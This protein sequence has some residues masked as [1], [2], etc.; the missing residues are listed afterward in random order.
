MEP[1]TFRHRLAAFAS[2]VNAVTP[3]PVFGFARSIG[4]HRTSFV[5]WYPVGIGGQV[6]E[7]AGVDVIETLLRFFGA[8][9]IVNWPLPECSQPTSV[10][11]GLGE[12]EPLSDE[13]ASAIELLARGAAPVL[14][15]E[16]PIES[17]LDRLRRLDESAEVVTALTDAL[18]V[19]DVFHRIAAI[20]RN[21]LPH[22]AIS[23]GLF[24][25][26]LSR[27]QHYASSGVDDVREGP[28]PYPLD[29]TAAWDYIIIDDAPILPIEKDQPGVTLGFHSSLRVAVRLGDRVIGGIDFMSREPATYSWTDVVVGRRIADQVALALS[30]QRL[31]EESRRLAALAERT[32]NLEML[33]GLLGTVTGVLDVRDVFT[34]ISEIASKVLPHDAM[35]LP[36]LTDDRQHVIPFATAGLPTGL[37]PRILPLPPS[38]RSLVTEP[39]DCQIIDNMQVDSASK[40]NPFALA[41]YRACLRVPVRLNGEIAG[42][43]AFFSK[44]PGMYKHED[45]LI[46]RRI[47]DHVAMVMSHERLADES[48]RA[49]ALQERAANLQMLDGLL[50]ALTGVLDVREVFDRISTIGNTVMPHDG[51]TITVARPVGNRITVYAATGALGHLPVPFDIDIP[52]ASLLEHVWDFELV[53]DLQG[54]P[55]YLKAPSAQAGMRGLLS[56]PFWLGGELKGSVNFFSWVPK[57]FT[58]DD[59]PIARRI[60]DHIGL[61]LSHHRLAEQARLNEELRVRAASVD[62]L[63]EALATLSDSGELNDVF[64]RV[65]AITAKVLPHDGLAL[66]VF[67]PDGRHARR[68]VSSGMDPSRLPQQVEVPDAVRDPNWD[69]DIIDELTL[70][71]VPAAAPVI[72][73]GM[74]SVLR[75]SVRLEGRPVAGLAF[76]SR[77]R[78]AFKK[79]DVAVARRVADR[80]ALSLARERGLEAAKRADEAT[81]RARK[82]ESRV[83]QLT[84]E[85]DVR[86]G[87]RRVVGNSASWRQVLTQAT[88]VAATETTVLLLGESGTGKEVVARLVHRASQRRDGPFIAL[89]CAALPEQLL[90]A[91]LFGYERGAFTGATQSKPGQ[92]EQASGGVLFLDE[93]GEMSLPAQAKFL[94]VLQE[95]E[96][97]RLGGTRVL[98]TDARIVA[99]TNRDL[100]KAMEQGHFREDLFYRLNVFAI[101]LPPLR[102]RKEDI[103]PLSDAFLTEFGRG[104]GRPPAG[105]SREAKQ[106]LLDYEW[107]G[108]VRELRNI[109]ERAAILCDGGLITGDHLALSAATVVR[110]PAP[111]TH[112]PAG[113]ASVPPPP[114]PREDL[115][116]VERAMIEEALENARFNKS[117]AA[118]DL[119]LSRHQL[120]VRMR[121]YGLE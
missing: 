61:A 55:R 80:V 86:T 9:R 120:Y 41:G 47:A 58:R 102:D 67:L 57:R 11:I 116:S 82:L 50:N 69:H 115:K 97:Q 113:A 112:V 72:K 46:A 4:G 95:R 56:I 118:K 78:A 99:A 40:D 88:Q 12:S 22:D 98:R 119:G 73:L 54:H 3:T 28:N 77:T 111:V 84:E 114:R 63:D 104:F 93:V 14:D 53:E 43:L 21:V 26:D 74:R 39:W 31:A 83:R 19:R 87:Y 117:K 91:E 92:L 32:A 71:A 18:D 29:L 109:L 16:E 44:R 103:L 85:L 7:G 13:D 76:L 64:D 94:R 30:H 59:V 52:D 96:F 25:D 24:N 36:I 51:M 5:Y 90:E 106:A 45:T 89:N 27:A 1:G 15:G 101:R 48:R 108:N 6:M 2:R 100:Q 75:I 79:D 17:K 68:Y 81:E 10:W 37:L 66:L 49:A 34:E 105:I 70:E 65:S 8:A 60:A 38:L 20:S 107:P 33:D 42:L 121:R 35:G 62:L 110:R 23:L